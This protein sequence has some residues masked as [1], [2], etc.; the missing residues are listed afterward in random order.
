MLRFQIIANK[1]R[2]P[3]EGRSVAYLWIDNWN[4]Y[5]FRTMFA[6][7]LFDV[8]GQQHEL[9]TVKIGFSG[10]VESI[11]TSDTLGAQ[12]DQLADNYFSVGQDVEYYSKLYNNIS[13]PLRN[14][15][16]AQLND[17]AY[18]DE[19]LNLAINEQVF[20]TSLIRSVHLRTIE[21]QYRGVLQGRAPT[22]DFNFR[23]LRAESED[24]G[25]LSLD[26]QVK[27]SSKPSTNI[28]T[29]IGRNGV[30]KTTILNG[31]V[32]AFNSTD[33]GLGSFRD[34][35]LFWSKEPMRDDYFSQLVGVSFS[36]FDPFVPP[37]N[38]KKWQY[39][40]L[41][42][43]KGEIKGLEG[44]HA[45]FYK[46]LELCLG[47]VNKQSRLISAIKT[48]ESD[49]NFAEMELVDLVNKYRVWKYGEGVSSTRTEPQLINVLKKKMS[50]GH[51]IVFISIVHVVARVEEKT[52]VLIDEPESHLHPPLLSAFI[53]AL[54]ELL[55]NRNGVG[56]VATH[57]PVVAQEVPRSCVNIIS[58]S[59][60]QTEVYKPEMET[61]AEN[62]GSLTREIFR[63]EVTKS[64]F[65]TLLRKEVDQGND[66]NY[67]EILEIFDGAIGFEGRAILRSMIANRDKVQKGD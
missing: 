22:T 50:S 62:V 55:H 41:K 33:T 51:A 6:V 5:S 66:Y 60:L 61:F 28:H 16:L 56:I 65:H 7:T 25:G 31:M 30:G 58:R 18:D 48:L 36:V 34:L 9:G 64:G 13:E 1:S 47:D 39:I 37:A 11:L 2:V 38:S 27:A 12:F 52:L 8:G 53:R 44:L 15:Y 10:Q 4:D 35:E 59:R 24:M 46:A 17:V 19:K 54:S 43:P 21:I 49:S 40:G 14:A 42:T 32:D 20:T 57:S 3:S 45:D 26:F 23:F 67:D 29:L 63:L